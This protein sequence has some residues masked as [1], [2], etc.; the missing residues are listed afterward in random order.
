M[1][2]KPMHELEPIDI[3]G[4]PM[5]KPEHDRKS[6]IKDDLVQLY[7]EIRKDP[8]LSIMY[9][10]AASFTQAIFDTYD[11]EGR[12]YHGVEHAIYMERQTLWVRTQ[13]ADLSDAFVTHHGDALTPD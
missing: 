8:V 9:P 10:D 11:V 7:K 2:P 5:G 6:F 1:P 4:K 13:M 12:S 3:L